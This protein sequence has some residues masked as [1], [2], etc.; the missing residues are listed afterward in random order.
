MARFIDLDDDGDD[1]DHGDMRTHIQQ[2]LIDAR[3]RLPGQ[4]PPAASRMEPN[5]DAVNRPDR[6]WNAVTEAFNCWP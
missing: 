3:G 5:K 4:L 1:V 6:V 2:H